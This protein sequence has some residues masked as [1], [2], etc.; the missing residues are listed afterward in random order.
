MHLFSSIPTT[1]LLLAIST[2]ITPTLSL[3]LPLAIPHPHN[4]LCSSLSALSSSSSSSSSNYAFCD[5]QQSRHQSQSQSSVTEAETQP[6]HHRSYLIVPHSTDGRPQRHPHHENFPPA[7]DTNTNDSTLTERRPHPPPPPPSALRT[8]LTTSTDLWA[9]HRRHAAPGPRA[10]GHAG[11][12]GRGERLAR[13]Y[14]YERMHILEKVRNMPGQVQE[15]VLG[16]VL[17]VL[18]MVGLL[19]SLIHI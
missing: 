8:W 10:E 11:H 7:Q 18:G 16:A 19:L 3:P 9:S 14:D 12:H 2:I 17:A 15:M 13:L 4:L 5:A 1:T 6:Q